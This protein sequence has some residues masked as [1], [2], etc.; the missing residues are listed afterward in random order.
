MAGSNNFLQWNPAENNM[1]TDAQYLAD[2]M[3]LNGATA[4][5][6]PSNLHNKFAYQATSF[7][8]A[9]AQ[10][11]ANKGYTVSDTSLS[12]LISVFNSALNNKEWLKSTAYAV[13]DVV[14][15]VNLPQWAQAVCT[16]AG[17]TG[18]SEP[19]WGTTVGA[20]ITDGTVVWLIVNKV[21]SIPYGQQIYSTA[22]TYTFVAPI[23]ARYKVIAV[24]GG[25]GG[26]GALGSSSIS[27]AG[28]GG[29]GGGVSIKYIYITKGTSISVTTGI[30]GTGGTGEVS[31][32][33]GG[34]TSFGSYCSATGGGG[35]SFGGT[36]ANR[37]GGG[38]PGGVGS[39]GDING[40]GGSGTG[41]VV[42][43]PLLAN[44][45]GNGGNGGSSYFSGSSGVSN[46]GTIINGILG[47]GGSGA[48][49]TNL[50]GSYTGG[51]GG[52]G[53]VVIEW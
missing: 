49:A 40:Y 42:A 11:L 24:G 1:Q 44:T 37:F 43:N 51:V 28:G 14:D 23:D 3:R 52:A 41:P 20:S 13:G 8:Y 36:T 47:S 18:S 46:N 15:S 12:S 38:S 2:S 25:G 5:I 30:G 31:G 27:A 33:T 4:Q 39:N 34:T 10:M 22:G 50:T 9:L 21:N 35:G 26:G 17:T 19:T 29:G 6:Y 7:I 32:N 16:T 53:V 48:D 45:G